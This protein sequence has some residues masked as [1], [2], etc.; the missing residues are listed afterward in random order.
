MRFALTHHLLESTAVAVFLGLL[1]LCLPKRAAAARHTLWCFAALKFALPLAFFTTL[2]VGLRDICPS[3][4]LQVAIPESMT[5]LLYSPPIHEITAVGYG[6]V[7]SPL[8][9]TWLI[10][11]LVMLA[12]WLPKLLAK[13]DFSISNEEKFEEASLER[14]K[15][16]IGLRM[17][18]AIRFSDGSGAPR[19]SG[20]WRPVVILPGGVS[21]VLSPAELE[22]VILH[23]LAHAKRRDNWTG[24]LVH[25]IACI[26]WFY[27]LPLWIEHRLNRERELACDEMVVR[28]GVEPADYVSGILNV[29]RFHFSTG[30]SGISGVSNSNLKNRL[31]VIMS[32][33]TRKPVVR[34]P[35][36]LLAILFGLLTI[37]P[38]M[39]G[40]ITVSDA[41]GQAARNSKEPSSQ[42]IP[43]NSVTCVFAGVGY[44]EGTVIQV[45]DGPEQMCA[46][47]MDSTATLKS[48]TLAYI[49]MW[50]HTDE[51]VRQRSKSK[52]H[53]TNPPQPPTFCAPTTSTKENA[54]SC[55]EAPLYS[56]NSVVQSATGTLRCEHGKWIPFTN[57]STERK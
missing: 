37:V 21:Q 4:R 27:P 23:E 43:D 3:T 49:P 36:T 26:F 12:M 42:A 39:I 44:P 48:G 56:H 2:G 5:G 25:T 17:K 54:C 29:C 6:G 40:L 28:S 1:I 45:A 34:I 20:L 38:L 16:I 11:S 15:R 41:N 24:A 35:K 32:L 52:V 53:L 50:I 7:L 18:I 13:E 22:A 51:T 33:S 8:V 47:V 55:E 30:I 57:A 9:L 31:E 19:L 14:L 10:G 46:R